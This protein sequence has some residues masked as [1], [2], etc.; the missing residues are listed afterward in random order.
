VGGC[1]RTKFGCCADGVTPADGA[2]DDGCP[3]PR[4]QVEA[5]EWQTM[6]G[7]SN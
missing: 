7:N 5:T 6:E 3:A 4:D 2:N 1:Q